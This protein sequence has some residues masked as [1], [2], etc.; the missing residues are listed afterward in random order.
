MDVLVS[1]ELNE[2]WLEKTGVTLDLV[3][4]RGNAGTIYDCLKVLLGMVGYT[5]SARL[6]LVQ[7]CHCLPCIDDRN[8]VEYLHIFIRMVRAL[9]KGEELVVRVLGLI[10]GDREM[11]EIEV[12][13]LEA[14]LGKTVV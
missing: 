7:L 9:L 14:E 2:L 11:Y 1:A 12:E 4:G 8:I 6:L 3:C 10:E 5:N 13:V